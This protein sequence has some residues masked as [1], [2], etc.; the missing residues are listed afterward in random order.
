MASAGSD[1]RTNPAT[2]IKWGLGYIASRYGSP[3]GAWA[4]S[5]RTGWYD[6]GGI[7]KPGLTM[8]LNTTGRDELVTPIPRGGKAATAGSVA[9]AARP[10]KIQ[11]DLGE[12]LRYYVE[13]VIDDRDEFKAGVGRL[14]R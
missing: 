1:W 2:Q 10:L 13:G 9:T 7:L 4:H 12:D 11:I 8:A 6:G 3:S 14:S 5:Q